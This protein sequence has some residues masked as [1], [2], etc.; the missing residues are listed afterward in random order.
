MRCAVVSSIL[1]L[2]V[3]W[4]EGEGGGAVIDMLPEDLVVVV[5]GDGVPS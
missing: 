5:V 1:R 2:G 4:Q 3:S